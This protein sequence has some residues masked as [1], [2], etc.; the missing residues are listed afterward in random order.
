MTR[1]IFSIFLLFLTACAP[2]TPHVADT[3][4]LILADD[5]T[6]PA[7]PFQNTTSSPIPE[8]E[9]IKQSSQKSQKPQKPV[10]KTAAK[11]ITKSSPKTKP[12]QVKPIQ[13]CVTPSPN[14]AFRVGETVMLNIVGEKDLSGLYVIDEAGFI[15]LPLIGKIPAKD[16]LPPQLAT[17]ITNSY[18]NGYLVNPVVAVTKGPS[19]GVK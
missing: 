14:E 18:R 2:A 7:Q 8:S 12:T 17:H 19:C 4:L 13:E 5:Y 10:T 3:D 15:S 11:P 6:P 16:L 1:F 9:P